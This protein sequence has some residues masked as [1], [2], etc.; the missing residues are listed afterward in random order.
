MGNIQFG[1]LLEADTHT[2]KFFNT[3]NNKDEHQSPQIIHSKNPVAVG[4]E[5]QSVPPPPE[6]FYRISGFKVNTFQY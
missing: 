6:F 1:G 5:I 3:P 4:L 2:N